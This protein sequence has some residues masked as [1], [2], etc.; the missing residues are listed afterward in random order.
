MA[1]RSRRVPSPAAL[2]EEIVNLLIAHPPI[3]VLVMLKLLT[4]AKDEHRTR[5]PR[6][7]PRRIM[8]RRRKVRAKK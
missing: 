6:R 1:A 2:S 4:L 8:R 3:G 7:K 5:R